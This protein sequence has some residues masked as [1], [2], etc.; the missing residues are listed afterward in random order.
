MATAIATATTAGMRYGGVW[1]NVSWL[2]S[3][4]LQPDW[5][6]DVKRCRSFPQNVKKVYQHTTP[7]SE[8]QTG[9]VQPHRGERCSGPKASAWSWWPC[10]GPSPPCAQWASQW[11]PWQRSSWGTCA[12]GAAGP[13]SP[14]LHG[15][16]AW[17]TNRSPKVNNT[18]SNVR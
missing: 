10:P 1:P 7:P 8:D 15:A 16:A 12:G 17:Q 2:V 18:F 3:G 14:S 13:W 5:P 9:A 4:R 6:R 11:A